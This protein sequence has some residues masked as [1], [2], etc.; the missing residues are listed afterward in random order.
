MSSKI[1]IP[2]KLKINP[3]PPLT[4]RGKKVLGLEPYH[5]QAPQALN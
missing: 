4:E 3:E 2:I 1:K 5:Q